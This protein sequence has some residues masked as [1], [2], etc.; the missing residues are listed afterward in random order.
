MKTRILTGLAIGGLLI[1]SQA[2]ASC[3]TFISSLSQR[4]QNNGV[5]ANEF[6]LQAMSPSAAHQAEGKIIGN[7]NNDSQLV[8]YKR[9]GRDYSSNSSTQST[10]STATQSSGKGSFQGGV[11]DGDHATG[12]SGT[13]YDGTAPNSATQSADN[14]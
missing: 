2:F 12:S 10:G 3:D 5:P 11:K 1:S 8:V 7:C 9:S 14:N 6:S 13:S 4:I